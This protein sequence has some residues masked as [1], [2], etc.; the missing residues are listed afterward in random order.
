MAAVTPVAHT[1]HPRPSRHA[2]LI[3]RL[4][5]TPAA[6]ALPLSIIALTPKAHGAEILVKFSE[7]SGI[8]A[9]LWSV[10]SPSDLSALHLAAGA[11]TSIPL[12]RQAPQGDDTFRAHGLDRISLIRTADGVSQADAVRAYV[13]SGLVEYAVPNH[14]YRTSLAGMT[15]TDSLEA[16]QWGLAKIRARTGWAVERGS[17]DVIVAIV[18][19]GVDYLHPDLAANV[20]VNAA[21]DLNGNRRFDPWPVS[22][23]GDL[24]GVDDDGNG[25]VDDV[26]GWDFADAPELPGTGDWLNRDN[27]PMDEGPSSH[28]THVAG[29]AC[30]VADNG[31]G[32]AGVAP[33]CRVMALRAGFGPLGYLQ[34]D[35]V[36]SAIVYAAQNGASVINMS[37][38]DVVVSPVIKDVLAYAHARGCV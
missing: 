4:R 7:A 11:R 33:G 21:E 9:Q 13:Q 18:D 37:W 30:A 28:G 29:I 8:T 32:V 31:I 34:E 36:S 23:G 15:G 12:A 16:Q 17:R 2:T 38:G 1:G 5:V 35:D 14:A 26:I 6:W 20:W 24:N 19:T 3:R 22:D 10:D 25:F 27:D